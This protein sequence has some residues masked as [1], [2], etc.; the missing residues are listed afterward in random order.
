MKKM[1]SVF[2]VFLAMAIGQQLFSQTNINSEEEI[3]KEK[4]LT[5]RLVIEN[6]TGTYYHGRGTPYPA[7]RK[8]GIGTNDFNLGLNLFRHREKFLGPFFRNRITYEPQKG[9]PWFNIIENTFGIRWR[10]GFFQ[11]GI[12]IAHIRYLSSARFKNVGDQG[13]DFITEGTKHYTALRAFASFWDDWR[14]G[15]W[16]QGEEWGQIYYHGPGTDKQPNYIDHNNVIFSTT[17]EADLNLIRFAKE[18]AKAGERP[19]SMIQLFAKFNGTY[20]T[21]R[22]PWNNYYEGGLGVQ[23]RYS[24]LRIGIEHIWGDFHNHAQFQNIGGLGWDMN[25]E[26]PYSTWRLFANLWLSYKRDR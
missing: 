10:P 20:D 14:I 18:E 2:C 8:I 1:I 3:K 21:K 22:Y 11:A 12:E 9:L 16:F 15:D 6:W 19:K 23:L 24:S 4:T 17:V 26:R 13:W 25:P 5:S 7:N